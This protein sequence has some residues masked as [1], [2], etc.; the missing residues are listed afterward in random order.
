MDC[1]S[2]EGSVQKARDCTEKV[3]VDASQYIGMFEGEV[4][5]SS[6]DEEA[7]RT[8][9]STPDACTKEYTIVDTLAGD[10][11]KLYVEALE[12]L[13]EDNAPHMESMYIW[14]DYCCLDQKGQ[15]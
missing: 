10:K 11:Y 9:P 3:K 13:K 2:K 8:R 5:E 4:D 14:M 12:K 15:K 7:K 6:E 1:Y